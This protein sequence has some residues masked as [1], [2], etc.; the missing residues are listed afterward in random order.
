MDVPLPLTRG[1]GGEPVVHQDEVG[2][3]VHHR[4]LGFRERAAVGLHGVAVHDVVVRVE[5]VVGDRAVAHLAV[6]LEEELALAAVEGDGVVRSGLLVPLQPVRR[7]V[8][9][10]VPGIDR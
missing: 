1:I 5:R 3:Q 10:V 2:T 6:L 7:L 8:A 9:V 4:A